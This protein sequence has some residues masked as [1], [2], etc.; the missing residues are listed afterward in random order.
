[1][2]AETTSASNNATASTVGPAVSV[3][4][5]RGRPSRASLAAAATS[6][7]S[8]SSVTTSNYSESASGYSTPLTSN[9]A[10]PAD[11]NRQSKLEVVIPVVKTRDSAAKALQ[12]AKD[13]MTGNDSKKKRGFIE[14]ADSEDDD[15]L[16]GSPITRRTRHDEQVA[17]Q[18]QED[19][20]REAAEAYVSEDD[21]G[22]DQDEMDEDSDD[23]PPVDTKGKGKSK[24]VAPR[25]RS[26]AAAK[27][28]VQDED[29]DEDDSDSVD[30]EPP[31]KRRKTVVSKGKGKGK[32]KA[33]VPLPPQS[34]ID[35]DDD[36]DDIPGK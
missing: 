2:L 21:Q 24:S 9:A 3:K 10:T 13:Y 12:K 22:E 17:R 20:D 23:F 18:L 14:V 25:P 33:K 8:V 31:V 11:S 27:T 5:P 6:G 19:L 28:V 16:D 7:D 29:E 1:M 35:D 30:F 34:V 36:G 15:L 4:R 26:R 32:A